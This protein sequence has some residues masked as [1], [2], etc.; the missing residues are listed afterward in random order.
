MDAPL[1]TLFRSLR[2]ILVPIGIVA[3]IAGA[4]AGILEHKRRGK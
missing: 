4:T 1:S 2:Q 3:G